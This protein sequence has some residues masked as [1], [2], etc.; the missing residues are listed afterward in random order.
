MRTCLRRV[1]EHHTG[2]KGGSDVA[3]PAPMHRAVHRTV[4]VRRAT[5]PA[6]PP[7][8]H[9]TP[10]ALP[11]SALVERAAAEAHDVWTPKTLRREID[12]EA[13]FELTSVPTIGL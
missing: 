8:L 1:R 11:A 4:T 2:N 10:F 9:G 6:L 3:P 5:P 7:V 13:L 12:G